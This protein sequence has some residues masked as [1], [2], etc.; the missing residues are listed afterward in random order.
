MAYEEVK[1]KAKQIEGLSQI[2]KSIISGN[3]LKEILQ[4]IVTMAAQVM[5]SKICS[6]MLLDEEKQELFIAATQSIS[7]DYIKKPNLKVSESVS[8][9]AVKEKNP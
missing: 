6:I 2:S 1:K 3:Y 9:K 7:Q 8:G 4:L 5:D